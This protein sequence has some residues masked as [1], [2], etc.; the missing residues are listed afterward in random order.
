MKTLRNAASLVAGALLVAAMPAQAEITVGV[1]LGASG[2][3]ASISIPY[4]NVYEKVVSKTLGGQPAKVIVLDDTGNP[5]EAVKHMRRLI[6]EDKADVILGST[7]TPAC[8]A[9]ADVALEAKIPMVCMSPTVVAA[10]KA[11]W[12]FTIPQR[13][14]VMIGGIVDHMKAANVKSVGFIGFTDGW[15]DLT[16]GALEQGVG[17]AGI[18]V[19][20]RERFARNDTS[21]TAQVLKVMAANPDAVFLGASGTPAVLPQATLVERGYKGKIYQTHGVINRDFLR[22]G[23]K[24]VEG[25]VAPTGPLVVADQLPDSN[26]MKKVALDFFKQYGAAFPDDGRNPF[27]GYAYDGWLVLQAAAANAVKKAKP[28]TPEF[29][30]ALRE[31]MENVKEVVGTHAVYNTS[32]SDHNGADSRARVMVTVQ[33]GNWKLLP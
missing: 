33:G 26:P 13:L 10:D 3:T 31:A 9:M 32:P 27:A 20:A 25:M 4:R 21:V 18:K 29:R 11:P 5:G 19:V 6:T 16:L 17:P 1:V 15:G 12:F 7:Y 24:N 22:V 28:G 14:P 23:G 2:P 8:L 30:A